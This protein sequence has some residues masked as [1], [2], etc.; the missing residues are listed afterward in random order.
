METAAKRLEKGILN[1][2]QESG[3]P[4]QQTR[5]GTMFSTF[6]TNETILDWTSV[7]T[8]DTDL[9]SSFFQGMLSRGVYIAPSQFEAG[10]I[11]TTHDHAVIDATIQAASESLNMLEIGKV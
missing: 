2:A 6:F 4:I 5:V 7:E 11:S 1:A 10:F 3:V 8:C 9:F